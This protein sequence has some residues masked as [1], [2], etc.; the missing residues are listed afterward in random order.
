MRN[1]IKPRSGIYRVAFS[2]VIALMTLIAPM[3]TGCDV[4][5]PAESAAAADA[6]QPDGLYQAAP[7]WGG[8][9]L[10]EW[11]AGNR[12]FA[13]DLYRTLF[14]GGQNLFYSPY[15]LATA[16][17]MTYAGA[18][19]ET[20]QQMAE[21]LHVTLLGADLHLAFNALDRTLAGSEDQEFPELL[22][23]N[24]L[25]GQQDHPFLDAFQ[26]TLE[27]YYGTGMQVV[28]FQQPEQ[29]RQ[30]INAWIDGQARCGL[31]QL[32]PPGSL[33][34]E[35]VLVVNNAVCFKA[36]WLHPFSTSHTRDGAFRLPDGTQVRTPLM[37]Q[38]ADLGY[39]AR[40]G[41]QA[42]ELPYAGGAL[43]MVLLLPE[44]G[45]FE[46]FALGLDTAQLDAILADLAPA[47]V[48][49]TVPRFRFE[50]AL[51]L[52]DALMKLGMVDAFGDAD[53]SGMDG[54][55]ELF[56]DEVYHQA[57]VAVDEAGTEATSASA[58]VMQMKGEVVVEQVVVVDQPFL[59][60]IRDAE[61]GA[62]LFLGH[63]VN[64]TEVNGM[65]T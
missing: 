10:P 1:I 61:N 65:H 14:D 56:V 54:T 22:F 29:A 5:R 18:R 34:A 2:L 62:I 57:L 15:G 59:F 26:D 53:F 31:K 21:A 44:A 41:V 23:A 4:P 63:V 42:V 50:T 47:G 7:G 28:D 25:W 20:E 40:P 64:P 58:A 52:K 17:A 24:A 30:I 27:Q 51:Q 6:S 9:L 60:L 37:E 16:L 45:T 33:D 38:L 46:S 35:T 48:Q 8:D 39:A 32:L 36:A 49:L 43:S 55:R 19:G 11:A 3:L 13:L 12:E